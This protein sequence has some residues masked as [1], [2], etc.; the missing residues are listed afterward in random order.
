VALPTLDQRYD[1]AYPVD[2]L[3]DW[4]GNPRAHD[5]AAIE[6]SMAALGFFGA[7]L[8]QQSTSRIIA[9]HGRRDAARAHGETTVPALV[10]DVDDDRATRMLIGDNAT[11]DKA[12]TLEAELAT[13]LQGLEGGLHGTTYDQADLARL[14]KRWHTPVDPDD[15]PPLP[16]GAPVT[17]PGD[18]W[19]LGQHR[20]LCG[21][22]DDAG[23][24]DRLLDGITPRLM[25]TDPPYFVEYDAG[26]GWDHFEPGTSAA[27]YHDYLRLALE[28]LAPTA[29]VYQW[30]ADRRADLVRAAWDANGLLWHQTVHWHKRHPVPSFADFMFATEVA[31]YGWRRGTR[32]PRQRRPP[33][34]ASN[35]WELASGAAEA[36]HPTIKPVQLYTDPY[37]GHLRA[38]EWAYEPFSGSGTAIAAGETIADD[39]GDLEAQEPRTDGTGVAL[40]AGEVTGR[41]VAAMEKDPAYVDVACHRWQRLTGRR[42]VLEATGAEHDFGP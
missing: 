7:V 29:P 38:G 14:V 19:I 40:A 37:T 30:H 35:V 9:G 12:R 39:D 15:A 23:D 41:R 26:R 21:R 31:A 1:P 10:V 8:V 16:V 22:C 13:L 4:P 18:L 27:L 20:L 28:H 32:P 6:E 17:K 3:L 11:S 34:N 24:V 42:P 33:L 36:D 5:D 25:V 2:K